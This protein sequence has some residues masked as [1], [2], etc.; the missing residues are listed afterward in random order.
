MC[1]RDSYV[2]ELKASAFGD[3]RV[4]ETMDMTTGLEYTEV[5]TDKT[6]G[7]FGLRPSVITT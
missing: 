6:S 7:V 5:Y 1:I 3:A 2:P 4:H